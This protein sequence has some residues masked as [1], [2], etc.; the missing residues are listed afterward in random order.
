[1]TTT[2][3]WRSEAATWQADGWS[4]ELR[5]DELADI[6]RG[7]DVILRAVRAVVRDRSWNTVPAIV[8]AMDSDATSL[9]L[10][11]RHEGLGA[12]V[13][14]TLTVQASGDDLLVGWDAENLR[15]FSTCRTGLVVLHP[16]SDSGRGVTVVHSDEASEQTS[17]PTRI[18]PHQPI[19]DIRALELHP[20][21]GADGVTTL[22]FD[23]DVFEMEDQRNWSDASFKTYSRP[24]SLPYPYSVA[25]G[26][27]VRQAITVNAALSR[28]TDGPV[29][30]EIVLVEGGV[31]PATGVEASTAPDPVP[32]CAD[33]SFRVVELDLTTPTWSAA[34]HR[35][36]ADGLPLD[37][38]LVA[39]EDP[40]PLAD[41]ASA[42]AR[43]PII[44]VTPFDS[45][46]HV[47]DGS[48]VA[49][50]RTALDE[51]GIRTELRAGARSHFTELN[52]E[53]T[54]IPNEVDGIAFTT[55]PLFHS[56]DTEQLVEALPMQRLIASQAV[57]MADHRPVH[58]GPVTLRPRFN[59]VATSPG[60]APTRTDL[61]EGYG[62]QF[63]GADDDRQS[64]PELA[65][66]TMASAA[67]LAIPGVA[68]ISWFETWGPR[69]L[70]D[71]GGE[72][73]PAAEAIAVLT[74]LA[75]RTLLSGSS[76]DGLL[77]AI[78]ARAA[79]EDI[80]LVSNLDRASRAYR[81]AVP[82]RPA[83]SGSL[84]AGSWMRLTTSGRSD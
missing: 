42:F 74:S 53:K 63:T 79:D 67:A 5:G 28:A 11:L 41:A 57:G 64:S 73:H 75:G 43:L 47:S 59:N 6:R 36:A 18:S 19:V 39:A 16:A 81:V 54:R 21:A 40:Q 80:V 32:P 70:R 58:I 65:A 60:P 30:D 76:P 66:W 44:A 48:I 17:F 71:L 82:G 52:R 2:S 4:L 56:L 46:L 51:A 7:G 15:E 24:L 83:L 62:A 13:L 9:R 50:T 20:R 29:P 37:V 45:V 12:E 84:P 25:A 78:G 23:G 1:M 35:A 33:G 49:R 22:R 68:S 61:G 72:P 3:W 14:S 31:F 69:G 38:R 34:L 77:W 26:E 10:A 8:T 27:R 55:T